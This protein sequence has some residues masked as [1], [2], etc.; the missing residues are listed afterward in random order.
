MKATYGSQHTY[1]RISIRTPPKTCN[2]CRVS[3][4]VLAR[5]PLTSRPPLPALPSSAHPHTSGFR[6]STHLWQTNRNRDSHS[7][8]T[9]DPPAHLAGVPQQNGRGKTEVACTLASVEIGLLVCGRST[10]WPALPIKAPSRLEVKVRVCLL[11]KVY[12]ADVSNL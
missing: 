3:K 6:C 5:S 1:G 9:D 8:A 2:H 7:P 4:L 11:P 12:D 10:V